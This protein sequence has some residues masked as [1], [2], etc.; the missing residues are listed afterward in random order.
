[1]RFSDTLVVIASLHAAAKG[2]Y[3]LGYY[4]HQDDDCCPG[5]QCTFANLGYMCWGYETKQDAAL[6]L[7]DTSKCAK[8][9]EA[10]YEGM[11]CC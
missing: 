9:G 8:E 3:Y 7:N 11:P 2:C 4:C 5:L 6:Q 10:T 1:M